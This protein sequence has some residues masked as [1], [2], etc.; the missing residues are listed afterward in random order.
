MTVVGHVRTV[1]DDDAWMMA[2][3]LKDGG[4]RFAKNCIIEPIREFIHEIA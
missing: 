4:N 2:K 1:W 3:A